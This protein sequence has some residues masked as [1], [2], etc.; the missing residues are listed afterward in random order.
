[1]GFHVVNSL[2]DGVT[3]LLASRKTNALHGHA[4]ESMRWVTLVFSLMLCIILY[5]DSAKRKHKHILLQENMGGGTTSKQF[6][7]NWTVHIYSYK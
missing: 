5:I 6:D 2:G 1:M 3:Y 7:L 4:L